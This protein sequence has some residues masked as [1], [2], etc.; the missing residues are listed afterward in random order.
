MNG[1]AL[2]E[3]ADGTRYEGDWKNCRKDGVGQLLFPDGTIY[4]GNF[5]HD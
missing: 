1:N 4:A 2:V 5:D 3:W